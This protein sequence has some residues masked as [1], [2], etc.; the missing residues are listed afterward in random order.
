MQCLQ[1][2][3]ENREG[4]RFCAECGAP[5]ASACPECDFA[6]Y[7]NA[8]FCGGCGK[9]LADTK[10][11]PAATAREP[12]PPEPERRQLTVMFCD[13]V[14]STALAER[15]D[16][17]ELHQLLAQYQ[18]TCA[19]VIHRCEGFIARYVGDGLLVY[20][21]YPKAHEDDPQ[22]AV[23]S[24]LGIVDAIKDLRTKF[25]NPKVDL[26]VRIGITTGLVVAGDIGSGERREEKAIV[27]ETPNLAA[28]LQTLAKPNSVVI[29]ASTQRL[30]EGL[31]DCDD[32]GSQELKGVSQ[33]VT[34]YRVRAESGAPSRFEAQAARGLTPLVGREGE[35]SLLL[36]RWE[37]A[38][39]GE[40]QVLLLSGEAGI[41]KSRLV[42]GFRER[43]EAEP[44]NR[45]LYYGSP[46]H[47]N[48]ALHPVIDQLERALRFEKDDSATRRLDKLDAVLSSLG[49]PVAQYVPL[50]AR[51]LALPADDRYP[52]S[53]LD[54]EQLKKKTL[55]ALL[56]IIQTMSAQRPVLMV[57]EDAHWIDPS[58]LEFIGLLMQQL[59]SSRL[60]LLITVRPEFES[61]WST[62]G[63]IVSLTLSRLG[64]K[65]STALI[66]KLTKGKALPNEVL[67]QIVDRTD[68]V[69]LF[70]EELTKTVLES[71][72]LQ[73]AGDRYTLPAP[74]PA[75]AIPASL[76]DSLMA[77]LDHLG[78]AKEIA[79][80]AATLGRSFEYKLLAAVSPL[81]QRELDNALSR[82]V[83][84]GLIYQRG[85][86]PDLTYE[87]KHALVQD[88]AYQ[89]LLKTTRQQHHQHIAHVLEEK[90]PE[91]AEDEPEL[92]AHH[93]T[94]AGL[95]EPAT[96]YWQRAGVR[97][98]ER[99]ANHE[100]IAHLETALKLADELPRSP[101][102]D[103]QQLAVLIALGPALMAIKGQG[104]SEADLVYRR[105]RE[106]CETV[107]EPAQQLAVTWGQW[108]LYLNRTQLEKARE[109]TE[110][111]LSIAEKQANSE[112]RLQAHHAACVTFVAL[113]ELSS[114]RSHAERGLAVY[115]IDE[116]RSQ[117]FHFGGHDPGVCCACHAALALWCLGYVD[118][119]LERVNEAVKLAEELSQ[120]AS[121]AHAHLFTTRIHQF[122]QEPRL[123]QAHAEAL[124]TS[125]AE[126]GFAEGLAAG[127][128]LRGW[129]L[130]N[131][132]ESDTGIE[133]MRCGLNE[134]RA[135]GPRV[136]YVYHL[137]LLADAYRQTAERAHGLRAVEEALTV[138]SET[139]ERFW[140]PE[141]YRLK[142]ELLLLSTRE[143]MNEA[144]ACCDR[145]IELARTRGAKSLELRAATSLARLWQSQGKLAEA[146]DLLAP[147][148]DW[149]TEGFD[150]A[151]L[152]DAKT[153]LEAVR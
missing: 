146:C 88:T 100:A 50:V 119:A 49:L 105:A 84:A 132:G 38:K 43:I 7:P 71:D 148:Y 135:T 9:P 99:S 33:P 52:V 89:S 26:A 16:P 115:N 13:L 18:D 140:E 64:R 35:I 15:L 61:P 116:H 123:T 87:F 98:S 136:R 32:L 124:I 153:V 39:D 63:Q 142:G 145:A 11:S 31:F 111:L 53:E 82:L 34:V 110:Q 90:F 22:R 23:R 1:C 28:R 108:I 103:R 51:L 55:E 138:A 122:R 131:E 79:Q 3:G 152:K 46:Y 17:E 27:G 76:Q 102:R 107:G 66:A 24:G 97:A 45:M 10:A 96:R 95:A 81:D 137:A 74:L 57:V 69:P 106:L 78:S 91:T 149:F 41:G 12:E 56:V 151:D 65:E 93:Y 54:P 60:F 6:N 40:G 104:A 144:Q 5:L 62:H 130:A 20:F 120:S 77:R 14:G 8:K 21:G 59:Q 129:A 58:T 118:Q 42:R 143:A 127:R 4:S 150:T 86:P 19:E 36:K 25:T 92:L 117:A 125:C 147:V 29:G 68:G 83:Q 44:H 80:L 139:G 134:W 109:L 141:L 113:D 85:L 48:S 112:A 133:E 72:L 73:D 128:I 30:V 75:P 67:D 70:I 94:E 126:Q 101:A 121:L 2:H 47:R 114:A 37:Q